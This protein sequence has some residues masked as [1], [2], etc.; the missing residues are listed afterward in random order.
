M[1]TSLFLCR[2]DW[3]NREVKDIREGVLYPTRFALPQGSL[4]PLTL[5]DSVSCRGGAWTGR[6]RENYGGA[7][8]DYEV[9]YITS[10]SGKLLFP[11]EEIR[12]IHELAGKIGFFP[13][14][15]D[16]AVRTVYDVID[17]DP[18]VLLILHDRISKI[19]R[20][21]IDLVDVLGEA[22]T[23]LIS[24]RLYIIDGQ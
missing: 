1:P 5:Q 17:D 22:C 15:W 19:K 20:F 13:I 18:Q 24:G 3:H 4:L 10:L 9:A 7:K 14:L 23:T 12:R 21:S 11:E 8:A 16:Q 6:A 2:Y